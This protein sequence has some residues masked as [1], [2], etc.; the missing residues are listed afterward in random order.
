MDGVTVCVPLV[1]SVPDQPPLPVHEVAFLL[2]HF[3]VDVLPAGMVAALEVNV[4]VGAAGAVVA[5]RTVSK[6]D[7]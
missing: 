3:K 6:V 5:A 2:D 4:T 7:A 1:A